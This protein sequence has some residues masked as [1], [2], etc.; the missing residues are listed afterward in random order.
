MK[1]LLLS[2]GRGDSISE[3]ESIELYCSKCHKSFKIGYRVLGIPSRPIMDGIEFRCHTCRHE[4]LIKGLTEGKLLKM[5]G[6]R[7]VA[8]L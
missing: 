8:Y 2:F 7:N 1:Q 4:A 3:V 6:A 5:V